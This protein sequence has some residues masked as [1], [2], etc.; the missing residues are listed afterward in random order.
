MSLYKGFGNRWY[1]VPQCSSSTP[2]AKGKCPNGGSWKWIQNPNPCPK[3]GTNCAAKDN[4]ITTVDNVE[5]MAA[6]CEQ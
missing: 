3:G 4:V 5:T 1:W 2:L 6:P